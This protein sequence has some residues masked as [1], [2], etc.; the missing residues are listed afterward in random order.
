MAETDSDAATSM[1]TSDAIGGENDINS[2]NSS[3][4]SCSSKPTVDTIVSAAADG[5]LL[6]TAAMSPSS[7][8]FFGAQLTNFDGQGQNLPQPLVPKSPVSAQR[9]HFRTE[10]VLAFEGRRDPRE[11]WICDRAPSSPLPGAL[12]DSSNSAAAAVSSK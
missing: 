5:L 11:V 2:Q 8:S 6:L 9:A 12:P 1:T 3:K 10:Q 7:S 4:M